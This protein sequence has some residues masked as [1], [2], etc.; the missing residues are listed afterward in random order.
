MSA[1]GRKR[2]FQISK[3]EIASAQGHV[4]RKLDDH[5][6]G[7]VAIDVDGDR[8]DVGGFVPAGGQLPRLTA[9]LAH[10]L[11]SLIPCDV[12]VGVDGGKIDLVGLPVKVS[13]AVRG[14]GCRVRC[15][16]KLE[17]VASGP[18]GQRIPAAAADERIA[19]SAT[20]DDVGGRVA[21]DDVGETVTRAVDRGAAGQRQVL[22]IVSE[23]VAQ[24][25]ADEVRALALARFSITWSLAS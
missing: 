23:R 16:R 20:G 17:P 8:G 3:N 25:R 9:K 14:G 7:A 11:E 5:I 15:V 13:N 2:T 10:Q 12:G 22:D 1:L 18:S 19:A 6:G 21:G 4:P 24:R